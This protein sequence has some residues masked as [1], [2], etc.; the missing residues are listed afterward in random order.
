MRR[1]TLFVVACL[2]VMSPLTAARASHCGSQVIIFSYYTATDPQTGAPL[3]NPATG[4][5]LR[6]PAPN[7][8]SAGCAA[9][10]TEESNT[11]V[12][13]PYTNTLQVR[14][15]QEVAPTSGALRFAGKTYDLRFT[16]T[17]LA[18]GGYTHDSQDI[19][20]SPGARGEAVATVCVQE[21]C[22]SATYRTLT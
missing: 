5:P 11:A 17:P 9:G 16:K 7:P 2:S 10:S 22:Q 19:L 12:L 18:T 21:D 15:R 1:T 3:T 8:R 6:N 20:V 13:Y 4:A 14:Y